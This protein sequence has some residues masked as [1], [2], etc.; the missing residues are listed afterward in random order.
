MTK[1]QI[2]MSVA[3]L[4]IATGAFADEYRFII[5][6]GYDPALCSTNT[7]SVVSSASS[8][9]TTGTSS[10]PAAEP[11]AIEARSRTWLES[12]AVGLKTTIAYGMQLI[13]R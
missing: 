4:C 10:L 1:K 9:L 3:A 11:S 6:P 12:I 13:F 2:C 7:C 8:H 5:T